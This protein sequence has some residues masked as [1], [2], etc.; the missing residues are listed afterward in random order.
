M[1]FSCDLGGSCIHGFL[2]FTFY[3][4]SIGIVEIYV[5]VEYFRVFIYDGFGFGF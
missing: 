1:E 4:S 3:F 5:D 2:V